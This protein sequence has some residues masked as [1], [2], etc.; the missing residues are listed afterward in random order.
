[1]RYTGSRRWKPSQNLQSKSQKKMWGNEEENVEWQRNKKVP[2]LR[3][4]RFVSINKVTISS[5]FHSVLFFSLKLRG[6]YCTTG[7]KEWKNCTF[8]I[9]LQFFRYCS[10]PTRDDRTT[11]GGTLRFLYTD[12][13]TLGRRGDPQT[14]Q[15]LPSP[16]PPESISLYGG[17]KPEEFTVRVGQGGRQE[18]Q[19]QETN[20]P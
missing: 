8:Y 20:A 1:M 15:R 9:P 4:L 17:A 12:G 13:G 11:K 6:H 5:R 19:L 10:L 18:F 7:Q 14:P 16:R 3:S 2:R